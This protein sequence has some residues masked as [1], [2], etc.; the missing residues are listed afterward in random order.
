MGKPASIPW[1]LLTGITL[2]ALIMV[3]VFRRI[4]AH[5]VRDALLR[6]HL[7]WLFPAIAVF[8]I[9]L[10]CNAM[11]WRVALLHGGVSAGVGVI[12]R[13]AWVGHFFNLILFGPT[14]G[15]IVKSALFARWQQLRMTQVLAASI[16]DRLFSIGGSLL[17][18]IVTLG[19]MGIAESVAWPSELK[20]GLPHYWWAL[21]LALIIAILVLARSPWRRHPFL[22]TTMAS[23]MT[24][25][26]QFRT[27][28]E[29]AITGCLLALAAQ[30][31]LSCILVLCLRAVT[32]SDFPWVEL[33]WTFPVIALLASI[34]LT[35]GGSGLREGAAL[36]LLS[37]YGVP[38]EDTVAAGLLT[39]LIYFLWAAAGGIIGWITNRRIK[40]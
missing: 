11:R 6:I 19:L 28:P 17:F 29:I 12:M 23:L 24:S 20:L 33:A 27:K 25:L 30:A 38:A 40:N 31:L 22:H 15:D 18:L 32:R 4:E 14:G 9:A 26:R 13:A 35:V 36:I 3:A 37:R 39:T 34:P 8:G 7:A 16:V 1:K 5:G 10:A 2:S 21:P